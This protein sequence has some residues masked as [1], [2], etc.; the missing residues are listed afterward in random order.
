MTIDSDISTNNTISILHHDSLDLT[1]GRVN[2]GNVGC[3]S[4]SHEDGVET[5]RVERPA[6]TNCTGNGNVLF[7]CHGEV[8]RIDIGDDVVGKVGDVDFVV[9]HPRET[10]VDVHI[11]G[12]VDDGFVDN[13][14]VDNW[15]DDVHSVT[16]LGRREFGAFDSDEQE[17]VVWGELNVRG[18]VPW[19]DWWI[20]VRDWK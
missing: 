10:E 15:E 2:E 13:F 14:A 20:C 12:S 1:A 18:G 5:S 16:C 8:G 11:W 3:K 7:N 19:D 4:V 17:I 9:A 6:K